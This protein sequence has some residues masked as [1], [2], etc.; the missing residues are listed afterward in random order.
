VTGPEADPAAHQWT[1]RAGLA[2]GA[3]LLAVL[4]VLGLVQ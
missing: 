3:V 1:G 2:I 4:G